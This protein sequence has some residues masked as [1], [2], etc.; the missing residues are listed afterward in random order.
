MCSPCRRS[1]C[2]TRNFRAPRSRRSASMRRWSGQKTYNGC[3][4]PRAPRDH[5]RRARHS[6]YE[7]PQ[8]RVAAASIAGIR[9][10][11]VYVP[12]GQT[13][14]SEK[15]AYKLAWLAALCSYLEAELARHARL[16][17][18]GDY[19]IAP[20][21]RDVHDPAAWEGQRARER[22]GARGARAPHEPW[23]DRYVSPVRAAARAATRWWDYR[24][25]AFRRDHGLRIDLILANEAL[26]RTCS[27][28]H[29]ERDRAPGNVRRITRRSL[30]ALTYS[31]RLH[32]LVRGV[33]R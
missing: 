10:I 4:D 27:V 2:R 25:G 14:G 15:F 32:R 30:R 8:R 9:V 24:A 31:T 29:I 28:C 17:V 3:R 19:N 1:S 7:D 12:N 5:R 22:T 13:V 18:L 11:N 21:D 16:L 6:G 20:E 23:S 33:C 26:A